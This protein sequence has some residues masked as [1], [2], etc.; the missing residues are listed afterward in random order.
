MRPLVVVVVAPLL[1]PP[2]LSAADLGETSSPLV[3][4]ELRVVVV[5]EDLLVTVPPLRALELEEP[6]LAVVPML[7]VLLPELF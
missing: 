6:L 7:R 3:S 2:V 5:P 4:P 1:L